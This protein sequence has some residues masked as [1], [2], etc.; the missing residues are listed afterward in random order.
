MFLN[1]QSKQELFSFFIISRRAT[2]LGVFFPRDYYSYI[3]MLSIIHLYLHAFLNWTLL[4]E[5]WVVAFHF[6]RNAI[7]LILACPRRYKPW[8]SSTNKL[9]IQ[10]NNDEDS[11]WWQQEA[12]KFVPSCNRKSQYNRATPHLKQT[13]NQY[14]ISV[15]WSPEAC[16]QGARPGH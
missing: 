4:V 10:D 8:F 1:Q 11:K 16:L 5:E 13:K 3:W 9:A 2:T 7:F 14:E 6:L 12:V 15:L